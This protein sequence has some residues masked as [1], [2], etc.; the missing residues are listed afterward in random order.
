LESSWKAIA[1]DSRRQ[2]LLVLKKKEMTPTEIAQHF[3]FSQPAVSSHLRILKS[4][5][6]IREKK[7][8]K[9]RIYSLNTDK[10]YEMM[11][12][13][14]SMLGYNLTSLKELL[15]NEQKN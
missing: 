12:L 2:I 7:I 8:G 11:K 5:D 1:D 4:S 9:N 14:A 6:L 3:K 15:E 13:F 10:T